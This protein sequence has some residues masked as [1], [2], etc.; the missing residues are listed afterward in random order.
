MRIVYFGTPQ[1]SA[2]FLQALLEDAFFDV[3]ALVCQPDEPVGRK[4][5]ITAPP[6]KLLF[7][8]KHPERPVFQPTK[9]KDP[10]FAESLKNLGADAFV[11]VAYGRII[12]Q[13]LLELAKLGNVNVHPSLLPLWRG[14]SPM[15]AALANGDKETGIS[16]MLIDAEMDHGPLLAQTRFTLAEKETLQ[17]LTERVVKEGAPLLTQELKKLTE[18][19]SQPQEQ[20]HEHATYCKLLSKTDGIINELHT[21]DEIERKVRAYMPWPGVRIS[22]EMEDGSKQEIKILAT[23]SEEESIPAGV[24]KKKEETLL[25]G[26]PKKTLAIHRLQPATKKEMSSR[27]YLQG[28]NPKKICATS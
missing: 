17:T 2:S 25:L 13:P 9:L 28:N 10:A 23:T 24:C 26:T 3:V 15:Q 5:I 22:L 21:A 4:K 16:I 6:T 14:P 11:I 7:Q 1:F 12:P 27:E 8:E 19:T 20:R 18:G